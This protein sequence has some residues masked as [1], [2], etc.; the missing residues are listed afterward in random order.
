MSQTVFLSS[1]NLDNNSIDLLESKVARL[2]SLVYGEGDKTYDK[3][4]SMIESLLA[5]NNLLSAAANSRKN[6]ES[7]YRRLGELNRDIADDAMGDPMSEFERKLNV[8]LTLHGQYK[9]NA[10]VLENVSRLH[11]ALDKGNLKR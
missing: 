5:T 1:S 10:S 7:M 2:E 9:N 3:P 8:V 11:S 4:T 6:I